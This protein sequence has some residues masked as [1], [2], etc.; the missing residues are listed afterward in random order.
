MLIDVLHVIVGLLALTAGFKSGR[1]AYSSKI[2]GFLWVTL[3]I[4]VM[5][6]SPE[7]IEIL[8]AWLSEATAMPQ[9]IPS[10]MLGYAT[11]FGCG[12]CLALTLPPPGTFKGWKRRNE[13]S[14]R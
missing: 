9:W 4:G 14:T 5:L 6:M 13:E 3:L 12:T 7:M 1:A 11:I 8:S 2:S 10:R